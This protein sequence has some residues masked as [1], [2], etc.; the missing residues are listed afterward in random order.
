MRAALLSLVLGAPAA[1]FAASVPTYHNTNNRHGL[2]VDPGL[3]AAA[4]A[5]IHLD[6]NFHPALSGQVFAQPLYWRPAGAKA[7]LLVVATGNNTVYGLDADNGAIVWQQQLP[8]PAPRSQLSCGNI[9]PEGVL[10]TPVIDPATGT[11]YVNALISNNGSPKQMLY[12]LSLA[13]G[14]VASGWPLDVAAAL[15]AKGVSFTAKAQGERGGLLFFQGALYVAYGGKYGDCDPYRGTVVQVAPS[16]PALTA[17]WQTRADR[18]GIWAQGGLV[19]DGK[20]I[21]AT[22][23]NTS[24]AST[25]MD[26]EAI[27]RLEPGLAHSTATKDYFAPSNWEALDNADLDLGGTQAIPVRVLA[28]HGTAPRAL[29]LGKDGNA[30]LVNRANLGGIGGELTKL[31][32]STTEIKTAAA[33]L[34]T[35][36][37]TLVAFENENSGRCSG[38]S[39]TTLNVTDS[40]TNPLSVAWCTALGGAGSPIITTTDGVANAIVWALG[41]E[42]NNQ[43]HGYDALTGKV[44]SNGGGAAMQGLHHFQTLISADGALY[45]AAD[46][47]VYRFIYK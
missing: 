4:A 33:V 1:A 2:Y 41:A 39:I 11:L 6:N 12:A 22:T 18:G 26:G 7:G 43:L 25:W 5:A 46:S 15:A 30:Y 32:V 35:A 17:V 27:V 47:T 29:A 19:S 24:G 14:S 45:V 23:G 36:S 10:G 16:P 28:P 9:N 13:D 37:Q 21:F 40:A 8:A 42:G 44:L 20:S 38:Q 34:D 31:V 3:T